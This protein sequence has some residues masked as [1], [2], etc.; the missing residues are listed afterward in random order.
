MFRSFGIT[1]RPLDGI[2]DD[3]VENVMKYLKRHPNYAVAVLEKEGIERH[4]HAQVWYDTAKYKGD[5]KKQ[6]IRI[7][8]N[9]KL[10]HD[11]NIDQKR[12]S[13]YVKIAYKDWYNDYLIE[14]DLKGKANILLDNPPA[15]SED[16][17]PSEQEQDKVKTIASSVDPRF[18]KYEQ[19]CLEYLD[20]SEITIR[21]VAGY[22]SFAMFVERS[23]K[24]I[25]HKRDRTA[26]CEVLYAYM[27]KEINVEMFLHLTPEEKKQ[28]LKLEQVELLLKNSNF[29]S[30]EENSEYEG[31]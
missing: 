8:S 29:L 2:T 6:M 27:K 7:V 12:H 30:E 21:S 28:K 3:T 25:I 22:L 13:V 23:I 31:A 4:L 19:D 24:V 5:I 10:V 20:G 9:S 11:W 17:Y 18:A 14:N 16:Y 15:L 1:I 26:L